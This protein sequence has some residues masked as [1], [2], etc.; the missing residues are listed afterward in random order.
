MYFCHPLVAEGTACKIGW[1]SFDSVTCLQK[2]LDVS[3]LERLIRFFNSGG[4]MTRTRKEPVKRTFLDN[5]HMQI[6]WPCRLVVVLHFPSD[7]SPVVYV[8][9]LQAQRMRCG[10]MRICPIVYIIVMR[11]L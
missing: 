8:E 6:N 1:P 7:V 11:I 4:P 9:G 5:A 10:P 2:L 3:G